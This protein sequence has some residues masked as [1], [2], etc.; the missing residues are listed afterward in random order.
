VL[1]PGARSAITSQNPPWTLRQRLQ[2]DVE[3]NGVNLPNGP[4]FLLTHLRYLGYVFNRES[5]V[6][7]LLLRLCGKS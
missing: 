1:I 6:V 7:L 3:R 5:R 4:I 2:A